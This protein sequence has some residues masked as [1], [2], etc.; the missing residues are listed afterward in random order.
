MAGLMT[1]IESA[2][3]DSHIYFMQ[4]CRDKFTKA[5][6]LNVKSVNEQYHDNALPDGL[7]YDSVYKSYLEKGRII[8]ESKYFGEDGLKRIRPK[9]LNWFSS[10][11]Y[12]IEDEECEKEVAAWFY[13]C[14]QKL[15]EG[16]RNQVE[17]WWGEIE[18]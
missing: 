2:K 15:Y 5:Y 4:V 6:E 12:Q 11:M 13:T 3:R 9:L 18:I 17:G 14:I 16:E 7:A 1:G 8:Y 10:V